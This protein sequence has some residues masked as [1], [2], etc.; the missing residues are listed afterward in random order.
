M[1]T[2]MRAIFAPLQTPQYP[3]QNSNTLSRSFLNPHRRC[4]KLPQ[5]DNSCT[6]FGKEQTILSGTF[7]RNNNYFQS[8]NHC[9]TF[10]AGCALSLRFFASFAAKASHPPKLQ[11]P[12]SGSNQTAPKAARQD[13]AP[14]AKRRFPHR[15]LT[16][17]HGVRH[18]K[19]KGW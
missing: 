2:S 9:T 17:G 3:L 5:N 16:D 11:S 8:W 10:G 12:R 7:L 4:P 13:A 19:C 1:G 14:A 15:I 18:P 6:R